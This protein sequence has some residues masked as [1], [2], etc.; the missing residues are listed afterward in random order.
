MATFGIA[1]QTSYAQ[2]SNDDAIVNEQ[3]TLS[4]NLVNN[5]LAQDILKK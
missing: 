5:P 3:I 4:D 1:I 2:N